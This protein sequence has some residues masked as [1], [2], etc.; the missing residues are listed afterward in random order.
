[1]AIL[2]TLLRQ[3]RPF[4]L[5]LCRF[6]GTWCLMYKVS[7]KVVLGVVK[8]NMARQFRVNI[9]KVSNGSVWTKCPVKFFNRSKIHDH[10]VP[11]NVAWVELSGLKGTRSNFHVQTAWRCISHLKI[12]VTSTSKYLFRCI[13][14]AFR[15]D[16]CLCRKKQKLLKRDEVRRQNPQKNGLVNSKRPD[17]RG[18]S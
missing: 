15:K 6:L 4:S 2:V 12:V 8:F 10:P 18:V 7:I 9:A 16:S 14:S 13:A 5:L 17:T 3:N 1:M 11:V